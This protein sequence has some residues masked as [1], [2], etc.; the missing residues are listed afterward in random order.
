MCFALTAY[1]TRQRGTRV[2][3]R[4]IERF[5]WPTM[6]GGDAAHSL[7][8]LI[9]KLRRKGVMI[10]RDDASCIWLPRD[11]ASI[12]IDSLCLEPHSLIAEKDLS[13]LPGYAP[14]SSPAF[15]DWVDEWRDQL[16]LRVLHDVVAA[17]STAAA[18]QDWSL[19]LSLA[20]QALKLDPDNESALRIRALAAGSLSRESP[21]SVT[22]EKL[23]V[24]S[25]PIAT[26]L[27]EPTHISKWRR[28]A[29]MSAAALDTPLVG[30]ELPAKRLRNEA[31]R[32]LRGDVCS[33]YVSAQAGIGKS[34]LVRDLAAW[35]S[36][37]GAAVCAVACDRL[38]G[39]H[40][41]SAFVEAV[42][43]L[44]SLPGAA[45]C[46][47]STLEC[48]ARITKPTLESTASDSRADATQLTASIRA[49]VLDLI[50]AVADEQALLLVVE[51]VHWIDPV[52]WS[53]LRTIAT[54]AN[55]SLLLVCTSRLGWQYSTWGPPETFRMEELGAL[56]PHAARTHLCDYLARLDRSADDEY[57]DWCVDTANGNPYFIEELVNYW[58][59]T[60][61]QYS[62]PPLLVALVEAR[63]AHIRPDAL[64]VI[65]AAAI[66]GK[67]STVDL[68]QRVLEFPTHTMFSSI[69]ELGQAALLT[70][71]GLTEPTGNAPVVCRHDLI[72]RATT[73]GLS[74]PGRALL[75]H[76]AARAIESAHED[77]QSA[78]L[79]WDCAEHWHAAGR[80]DRSVRAAIACARHLY[81]MGLVHDA[82]KRCEAT[83]ATCHTDAAR[84]SVLRMMAQAQYAAREWRSFCETVKQIR[85]LRF[86][87]STTTPMHDDLE[88]MEL[89]V[90]R[91]LHR[92]WNSSLTAAMRCVNSAAADR[93]HRVR[94]AIF[95]LKIA[96]NVGALDDM[97][98]TYKAVAPL[99]SAD[100]VTVIDR[101]TLAMVYH[102]IRG[103]TSSAAEVAHELL[104]YAERTLPPRHRI[105]VM[106]DCAEAL[107]RGAGLT[108]A[109][110]VYDSVFHTAVPLR[111]FDI[112]ASATH[113]LIE[114]CCDSSQ[115]D[116]AEMCV[117][118]YRNLRR[119]KIELRNHRHLRLAI[120]R[121]HVWRKEWDSAANLM[122]FP[123]CEPAWKDRVGL[124]R[125]AALAVK[126]RLDIG[127]SE[128]KS[129]LKEWIAQL[130]PL[131]EC[132]RST[133]TQD[134]E[135]YSLY[136][137]HRYV[138]DLDTAETLLR[139]YVS[140]ER[141][142]YAPLSLEITNQIGRLGAR[143]ERR[144]ANAALPACAAA[145]DE[146][147]A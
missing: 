92:E 123:K 50:D 106:M 109:A 141:R 144:V 3:R 34:R 51:D 29:S 118:R 75:H 60:G 58:V 30:R 48:L 139:N 56:D 67:H 72:A 113:R 146:P 57:L 26:Q 24:R 70:I 104:A 66:L 59:S 32:A 82:V 53:L 111:C 20:N 114:I 27:R 49:S 14:R 46:A 91:R 35:M 22:R 17:T 80:T 41:L 140:D 19:A 73:R 33:V 1:L 97:D 110:E 100:D 23:I 45:G 94:A 9:H 98:V 28:Q 119:P 47:P 120:A 129:T 64:R 40:P 7:S 61:E 81:D 101:L 122:E 39:H 74:G 4:T 90:Q 37:H 36:E 42:P 12:D 52:S 133:G 105:G 124:F 8:E 125:S 18:Q 112:A 132:M 63:L 11:A 25:A 95:A 128:D 31:E 54:R 142:D 126:I 108:D 102:A 55:R 136:L 84:E 38:D 134:Y 79:L 71:P 78:E 6:R 69:E 65:Q 99:A 121:V 13:I 93:T 86:G 138:G 137:A 127:R 44:Q 143:P 43:I 15:N 130:A 115:M 116:R 87:C 16:Q 85:S 88:L 135:T 62:A 68:L 83:L 147:C 145:T 131:N 21:S 5:F 103:E 117:T 10:Q 2:S 89:N 77:D 76:A 107:R 96:T